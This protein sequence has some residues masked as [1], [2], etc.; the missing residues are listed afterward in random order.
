[1]ISAGPKK[2]KPLYVMVLFLEK[3]MLNVDECRTKKWVFFNR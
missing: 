3:P 1:M 2:S